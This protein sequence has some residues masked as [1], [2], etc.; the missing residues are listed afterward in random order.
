MAQLAILSALTTLTICAGLG[1]ALIM[2]VRRPEPI[3][4]RVKRTSPASRD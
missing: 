4:V 1:A 3:P 2:L